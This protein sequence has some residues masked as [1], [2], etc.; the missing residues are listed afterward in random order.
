MGLML[1]ENPRCLGNCNGGRTPCTLPGVCHGHHRRPLTEHDLDRAHAWRT[2]APGALAARQRGPRRIAAERQRRNRLF[3]RMA[4]LLAAL[5]FTLVFT[6]RVRAEGAPLR[7]GAHLATAHFA[8]QVDRP[9][10]QPRSSTPGLYVIGPHYTAGLVRN[11][12]GR[13]SAYG[14]WVAPI[15][16]LD[17]TLGAISGYRYRRVTGPT[18]CP[19]EW[20]EQQRTER[21]AECWTEVGSTRHTLRALVAVSYA[22]PIAV[23]GVS[24]RITLLGRKGLHLSVESTFTAL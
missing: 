23:A 2:T 5:A 3:V 1:A 19:P 21:Q 7:I 6:G 16:P 11:S 17:L 12:Y 10:Q 24:P 15:G 22:V 14:G 13:W 8:V 20:C 4:L 9:A 18:A